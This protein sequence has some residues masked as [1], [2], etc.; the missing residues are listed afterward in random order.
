MR[1]E[2]LFKATAV[3]LAAVMT[4]GCLAGCGGKKEEG[5]STKDGKTKISFGI[6]DEN[7]RPAMESLAAAYEKNILT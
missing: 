7:Q 2:S 1:K 5:G 6:W 4:V 3:G